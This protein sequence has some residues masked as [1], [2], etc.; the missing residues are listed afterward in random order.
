MT[1]HQSAVTDHQSL[2]S[3]QKVNF[4]Y[5]S[6]TVL[7]DITLEITTGDFLAVIGPN[8][9]GKTTLLKLILGILRPGSG[10]IKLFGQEIEKFSHWSKLGYVPQKATHVD[11]FFPVSAQEVVSMGLLSSKRF[12]R[13]ITRSDIKAIDE[14]LEQVDMRKFRY[15]RIGELS[16]GQQQRIFIARAI[17]NQPDLLFLDEPTTGVDAVTQ[18]RFYDLLDVLNRIRNI[19]IVLIT[20]DIGVVSKYVNKVACLNQK[21]V[22]HGNHDEFCQSSVV[23]HFLRGEQHLICHRH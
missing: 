11:P 5:G 13:L 22:F 12:P 19:T 23:D 8:G 9:S 14:A 10:R 4:T 1:D 6:T 3:V 7:S 21:L 15:R 18:S 17:V 16:G 20:H 2:V